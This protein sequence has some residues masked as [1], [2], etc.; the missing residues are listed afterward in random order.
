MIFWADVKPFDIIFTYWLMLLP[1][2]FM[3]LL[4]QM[5]LPYFWLMFMPLICGGCFYP[6]GV[7]LKFADIICMYG[8]FSSC[9]VICKLDNF[10]KNRIFY[11]LK[12]KLLPDFCHGFFQ[13]EENVYLNQFPTQYGV[14]VLVCP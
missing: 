9:L 4:W 3:L 13:S 11:L 10:L 8:Y 6:F 14:M 5:L 2:C 1:I 12:D 7:Y